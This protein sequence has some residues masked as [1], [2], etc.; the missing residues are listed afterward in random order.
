M[1]VIRHQGYGMEAL[2]TLFAMFGLSSIIVGTV[3]YLLGKFNLGRIVYYFPTH[4]LVGAIGGIGVF[5]AKTG[6]EVTLDENLSVEVA[7]GHTDLLGV[8]VLF[9]VG[10]RVLQRITTN[11]EGKPM[12]PLLSPIYFCMITPIFYLALWVLNVNRVSAQEA[13]YFFPPLDACEGCSSSIF[14][15]DLL[16]MW[17]VV[18][19]STISWPAMFDAIPTLVALTLFSL[20]HVPINI[21]AFAISTDTEADMNKE[22]MAHGYSNFIA[23]IFGGLQNYMAYTQSVLYDRSG[24]TGKASGIAVAI[25]T[26][27]LFFVGPAIASHIPRCMAGTLLLHV[28]IDLFLEGVYDSFGKFDRLEY[29]GIWLIT[30]VMT[31]YGKL[32]CTKLPPVQESSHL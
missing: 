2:S 18:N 27:V 10:L 12:Y 28:G 15:K 23:G 24:G 7:L 8:V 19:L 29:F 1:I 25:V 31:L 30:V 3:F 5:I 11:A 21:P 13:G 22:L 16:N 32:N 20:I 14:N 26:S 6:I 9:E 4:V 17:R